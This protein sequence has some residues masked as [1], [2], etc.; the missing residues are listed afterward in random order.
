MSSSPS[1]SPDDEA[2][3]RT[4]YIVGPGSIIISLFVI[5]VVTI[6]LKAKKRTE[7][8]RTHAPPVRSVAINVDLA[9]PPPCYVDVM[10]NLAIYKKP[11][12]NQPQRD[13][14]LPTYAEAITVLANQ[15]SQCRHD[16]RAMVEIISSTSL[17]RS[18]DQEQE[19]NT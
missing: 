2:L 12:T 14:S 8:Q 5:G 9:D 16:T 6:K 11:V 13:P 3:A 17:Q 1:P 7:E 4:L 15:H 18:T 19:H 10:K